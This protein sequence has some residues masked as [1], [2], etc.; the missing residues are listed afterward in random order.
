[1]RG[2][3]TT[4]EYTLRRRATLPF[5]AT[6]STPARFTSQPIAN[7]DGIGMWLYFTNN[8]TDDIALSTFSIKSIIAQAV[9]A[10]LHYVEL[11]TAYGAYWELTPS[12]QPRID[13]L[14]DGLAAHHIRSIGWTVPRSDDFADLSASI[15]T[16]H[17]RTARGNRFAG[18][19]ID[20]SPPADVTRALRA[21]FAR[22]RAFS[23]LPAEI[24]TS[25]IEAHKLGAIGMRAF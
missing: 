11:R 18:L 25:I 4:Y 1:M 19:A 8:P 15:R 17:Y 7:A 22:I 13:A 9:R 3:S 5:S 20:L 21:S 6:V 16:L 10:H 2:T 24:Q 23:N 12:A 14:I